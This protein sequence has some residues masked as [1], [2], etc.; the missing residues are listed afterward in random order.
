Q[1]R[2]TVHEKP[3]VGGTEGSTNQDLQE[4]LVCYRR[5]IGAQQS[6]DNYTSLKFTVKLKK[7]INCTSTSCQVSYETYDERNLEVA[8]GQSDMIDFSDSI[9]GS[10][11]SYTIE[12]SG[13]KNQSGTTIRSLS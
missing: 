8:V 1:V 2:F 4:R 10:S 13:V 7:L 11:D 6:Q 12:V 3:S 9:H 5:I